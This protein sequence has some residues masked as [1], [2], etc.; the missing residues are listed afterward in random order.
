M[1]NSNIRVG[2]V[3][4]LSR[5][6]LFVT[7]W[8]VAHQAPL[9]MEFSRHEYWSVLPPRDLLNSGTEPQSLA[10][11]ASAGGFFTTV[12]PGSSNIHVLLLS[13]YTHSI[14]SKRD[15]RKGLLWDKAHHFQRRRHAEMTGER[16]TQVY[17]LPIK[18]QPRDAAAMVYL[19]T[20]KKWGWEWQSSQEGLR[21]TC[22][23]CHRPTRC[24][25]EYQGVSQHLW[26]TPK[27][28]AGPIT[29]GLATDHTRGCEQ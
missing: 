25:L 22:G 6:W 23:L 14:M 4:A 12:L 29:D 3:H 27:D 16:R 17:Q 8:T 2:C 21:G 26:V 15:A 1:Y 9:S 11:P 7:P 20:Q 13:F 10:S 18:R 28:S 5:I 24:R 19:G